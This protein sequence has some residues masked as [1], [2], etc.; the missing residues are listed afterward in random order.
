LSTVH[1]APLIGLPDRALYQSR[2]LRTP[3]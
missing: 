1:F 3:V 2:G